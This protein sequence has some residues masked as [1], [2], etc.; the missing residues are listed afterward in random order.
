M[1]RA[2]GFTMKEYMQ[3]MGIPGSPHDPNVNRL[4]REH[5]QSRGLVKIRNRSRWVWVPA[6]QAP[7]AVSYEKV[8]AK[9][10]EITN[11]S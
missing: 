3:Q 9:L 5:F 4:L 8:K 6:D 10:K 1:P 7:A 11:G 2:D